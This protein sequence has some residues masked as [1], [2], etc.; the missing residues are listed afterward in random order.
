M[1]NSNW[2]NSSAPVS[3]TAQITDLVPGTTAGWVAGT[4]LSATTGVF[5]G[6]LTAGA[7]LAVTGAA[8]FSSSV[9]MGA[10]T[11][12]TIN[13]T[14]PGASAITGYYSTG[15][16][17][18]NFRLVSR[19]GVSGSSTS[20]QARFGL[21]YSTYGT[22]AGFRFYR[23]GGGIDGSIHFITNDT[24][25]G[26]LDLS[27][28]WNLNG[29]VSMGALSAAG[30]A[31]VSKSVAGGTGVDASSILRIYNPATDLIGGFNQVGIAFGNSSAR[32]AIMAGSYG[33]DFLRFYTNGDMTTPKLDIAASGAATFASSV[34]MGALTATT[35]SFSGNVTLNS[36]GATL[37]IGA[38]TGAP[39]AVLNGS[40]SLGKYFSI[41]TAGVT[42]WNISFINAESTGNVGSDIYFQ[43]FNDA[44]TLIDN[45]LSITRAAGGAISLNRPLSL[46]ANYGLAI[47]D[48]AP[49]ATTGNPF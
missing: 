41:Q 21:E 10:L 24:D 45:P 30:G 8:T 38:G 9:S 26:N 27:G 14:V 20:E 16:S 42:R 29:S 2:S 3:A 39:V 37:Y 12:T 18:P 49:G 32:S 28:N 35:G 46:A 43:A 40:A 5:S 13:L 31:T 34:S 47:A 36:A 7:G 44:G 22:T 1:P 23:G 33:N 17:D 15:V 25:R 6:L 48:G 11:A 4:A 19:N